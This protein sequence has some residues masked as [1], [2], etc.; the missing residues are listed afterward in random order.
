MKASAS[1]SHA[2]LRTAG[3]S[4]VLAIAVTWLTGCAARQPFHFSPKSVSRI[5]YDPRS[6][7]QMPDG[8]FLCR[9]VVFT[10]TAV[11]VAQK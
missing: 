11:D 8:K 1:K 6:C 3:L 5:Q 9:D 2:M 10:V 4:A 7:T